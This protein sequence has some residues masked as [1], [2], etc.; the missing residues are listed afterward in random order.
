MRAPQRIL[1]AVRRS[2]LLLALS[3][4]L[5]A[6]GT[7]RPAPDAARDG[8][9]DAYTGPTPPTPPA[10]P[11][12]TPCPPSWRTVTSA[13]GIETCDPYPESGYRTDCAFDEA[14]WPGTPG[15][16]RVGTACPADG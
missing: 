11:V 7:P 1:V 12:L 4:A 16:T 14:H 8:A 15:C 13:N 2:A 6:C 5:A 9:T 3:L 10:P